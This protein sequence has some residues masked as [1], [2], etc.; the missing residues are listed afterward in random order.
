MSES[1]FESPGDPPVM[2]PD[3]RLVSAYIEANR[4][5]DDLP[6]TRE[7]DAIVELLR[8][9]GDPRSEREV[10]HRLHNLRKASK[11]PRVG[12]AASTPPKI[13][14]DEQRMLTELVVREVGSLGKRD[15]LPYTPEFERLH[16]AFNGA[17]G[18][19]VDP[20]TLWRL[21]AKLAK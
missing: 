2:G 21:V 15:Q 9:G 1:L 14:D 17:T 3:E 6:Y 19:A 18:R 7:L 10:L 16:H 13:S 20:H 12:R 5:L 8:A 11:L 4:T